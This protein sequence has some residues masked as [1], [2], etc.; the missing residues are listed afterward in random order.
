MPE[1]EL[2]VG[3]SISLVN[4]R[5][6]TDVIGDPVYNENYVYIPLGSEGVG[7]LE[8]NSSSDYKEVGRWGSKTNVFDSETPP[9]RDT[10]YISDLEIDG[11]YIFAYDLNRPIIYVL[12]ISGENLFYSNFITTP[13][14]YDDRPKAK[15]RKSEFLRRF[16]LDDNRLRYIY[17]AEIQ[18]IFIS[19]NDEG[20]F[21]NSVHFREV[22]YISNPTNFSVL[23]KV[24]GNFVSLSNFEEISILPKTSGNEANITPTNDILKRQEVF[25]GNIIPLDFFSDQDGTN[26]ILAFSYNLQ[27]ASTLFDGLENRIYLAKIALNGNP[28]SITSNSFSLNLGASENSLTNSVSDVLIFGNGVYLALG[29]SFLKTFN[30]GDL[31]TVTS[32]ISFNGEKILGLQKTSANIFVLS[33]D[34][35]NSFLRICT[36]NPDF[37][38]N[39]VKKITA[40]ISV[41]RAFLKPDG[42]IL[43]FAKDQI[44]AHSYSDKVIVIS[45]T[46][47]EQALRPFK[48]PG[49]FTTP[50]MKNPEFKA[51]CDG[52]VRANTN[53]NASEKVEISQN[54]T[55]P[56]L[57]SSY[58]HSNGIQT[59]TIFPKKTELYKSSLFKSVWGK[60]FEESYGILGGLD[61]SLNGNTMTI[62]PGTF[63]HSEEIYES[64]ADETADV[65]GAV[66]GSQVYY[67]G[68][69]F[70]F[71]L[72]GGLSNSVIVA[73]Y[74]SGAWIMTRK[75]GLSPIV[76]SNTLNRVFLNESGVVEFF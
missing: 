41:D 52:I 13:T 14:D 66:N 39:E 45:Q 31:S 28:N 23:N 57:T 74:N 8:F 43:L 16:F 47:L 65:S 11:D 33:N 59:I 38:L 9:F 54:G 68:N 19:Q 40:D 34:R 49:W 32:T 1:K 70:A 67:D 4:E 63:I 55:L 73:T 24:G 51:M 44:Y 15:E 60:L 27:N 69:V 20:S 61:V 22:D 2:L 29:D 64:D 71:S 75:L 7:I 21:F 42:S 46:E 53:V 25:F 58:N 36:Q 72:N 10:I 62:G 17:A 37:S 76:L 5:K 48:R 56:D 18:K 6:K 35:V 50:I 3:K 26:A 12:K 30:I